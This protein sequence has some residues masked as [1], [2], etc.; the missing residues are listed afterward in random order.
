MLHFDGWARKAPGRAARIARVARV[1]RAA[2]VAAAAGL[3][4]LAPASANAQVGIFDALARTFSDVS[5]Y[6]NTGRLAASTPGITADRL[7]SYGIEV[8]LEV[9]SVN[10]PTGAI[11]QR[12]DSVRLR[13][14]GMQ[15]TRGA[16]GTDTVYTYDVA[17]V[18]LA[19]PV[20]PVWVFEIGVGYG[21]TT[22]Y[23]STTDGLELRGAVRDLP[24]ASL[25]ASYVPTGTYLGLRSGFMRFHGLQ[26]ID[27]A[28]NTFTGDA[29]AFRA[30]VAIGQVVELLSLN[31]FAEAAYSVRHFPSVRWSGSPLPA[32]VPRAISVNDW[33]VGAGIQFGIG[34][35]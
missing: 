25:Y 31:F 17:P 4:L 1:A 24:S 8:L 7:T 2:R 11:A 29:D 23:R 18:V 5:F 20:E 33:T 19:A 14:T 32:A 16:A 15:V 10:R 34:R 30:G 27:A 3:L 6:A 13:W 22:G 26:V 28:G 21:Q 9:G 12:A 35:N